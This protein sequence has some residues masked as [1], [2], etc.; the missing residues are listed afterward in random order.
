[1]GEIG[2]GGIDVERLQFDGAAAD[3]TILL[4]RIQGNSCGEFLHG[5]GIILQR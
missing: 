3:V 1:M 5:F 2:E 4:G